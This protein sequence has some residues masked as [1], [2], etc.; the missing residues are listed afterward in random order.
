MEMVDELWV[1][2]QAYFEE[3]CPPLHVA[4]LVAD[5]SRTIDAKCE[6]T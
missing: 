5:F 6:N 1:K 2:K 3:S 4:A